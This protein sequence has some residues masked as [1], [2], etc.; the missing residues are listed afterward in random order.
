M[1]GSDRKLST[2]RHSAGEKRTSPNEKEP[3]IGRWKVQSDAEIIESRYYMLS[4]RI[5]V[6]LFRGGDCEISYENLV[7]K[8]RVEEASWVAHRKRGRIGLDK[9]RVNIL[10]LITIFEHIVLEERV[11]GKWVLEEA[12]GEEL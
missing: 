5:W 9:I 3:K 6:G 12:W 8:S 11:C 4:L 10:R 2:V 1:D 7:Y